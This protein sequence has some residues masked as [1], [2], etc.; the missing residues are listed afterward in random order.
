VK[1]AVFTAHFPPQFSGGTEQV[2]LAHALALSGRGHQ[3]HIVSGSDEA[4][5]GRDVVRARVQGLQVAFLPRTPSEPMDLAQSWPRVL[6]LAEREA[7]GADLIIV[8]HQSTLGSGLVRRLRRSAPVFLWLHD[9]HATCPRSFRKAPLRSISC[10][11]GE[12]VARVGHKTCADCLAPLQIGIDPGRTALALAWRQRA[13]QA[14][15]DA[16]ARVLVPS[17]THLVRLSEFLDFGPGQVRLLE[18]GLCMDLPRVRRKPRLWR[19]DGP[20][21]ILHPGRR[22][23]DKGSL[24]LAQ[25]VGQMP[26]GRVQLVYAGGSEKGLDPVLERAV[27]ENGVEWH[28][29]YDPGQLAAIAA[30]CHVVALPS[31][32]P[33]S[34]SL[35]VDEAL[36]LG[37]PVWA[38]G[39]EAARE[40]Y[41]A[42][43]LHVLPAGDP[44]AWAA[45]F[46]ELIRDPAR[47]QA[48]ML[49]LPKNIPTCQRTSET[50]ERW[51]QDIVRQFRDQPLSATH[52]HRR[53]A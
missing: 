36:A 46:S 31:R 37:L 30:T 8:Y 1:I 51:G 26:A 50:L 14:E 6:D 35:C 32:L 38:S 9:H 7:R 52:D 2:A 23:L 10:P 17:R 45:A 15:V 16:A 21:R 28:G 13:F 4:H 11:S 18:P 20:L 53:P 47:V 27:G 3:V 49:D 43:G 48:H 41:G 12:E 42:L 29:P 40:R 44:G 33:E 19:G 39:A 25:A 34:Y 5:D 22:S 24:D